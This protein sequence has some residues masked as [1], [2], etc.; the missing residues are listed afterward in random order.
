MWILGLGGLKFH[1]LASFIRVSLL[2][3]S[4]ERGV[5]LGEAQTTRVILACVGRV[6]VRFRNKEQ[7]M[8]VKDRAFLARLKPKIPFLG[9]SLLPNQTERLCRL[10]WYQQIFIAKSNSNGQNTQFCKRK[11]RKQGHQKR[12]FVFKR[13][14]KWMDF[15]LNRIRLCWHRWHTPLKLTV[16]AL[17]K[18]IHRNFFIQ[19]TLCLNFLKNSTFNHI[20]NLSFINYIYSIEWS[21][22]LPSLLKT[23]NRVHTLT[24][25]GSVTNFKEI[26][27]KENQV[28]LSEIQ[29]F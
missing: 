25:F 27:I 3:R 28:F 1:F 24:R 17:A 11:E 2:T 22:I 8:R 4:L 18:K 29:D 5:S 19:D 14:T 6:S 15:A 7:G 21:I 16:R 20:I 26:Q 10:V 23:F 9:L 12:L 13:V